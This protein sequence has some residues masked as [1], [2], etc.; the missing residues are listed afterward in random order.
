LPLESRSGRN[1]EILDRPLG[2]GFDLKNLIG[3]VAQHYLH[4]AMEAAH[5]N[6]TRAA[7]LIG[8]PNYQT[9]SNWLTKYGLQ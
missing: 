2:Q 6:K 4:R 8:L 3:T 5:G 1:G 7:E 9:L